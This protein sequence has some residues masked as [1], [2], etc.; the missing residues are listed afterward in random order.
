[1]RKQTYHPGKLLPIIA[2]AA[3]MIKKDPTLLDDIDAESKNDQL[4][5]LRYLLKE[6]IPTLKDPGHCANCGESMAQYVRRVDIFAALLTFQMSKIVLQRVKDGIPFTAANKIRVNA[7]HS[8]AHVLKN[9]TSIARTL[10]LVARY[11][12]KGEGSGALWVVTARGWAAL[13]GDPIPAQVVVFRN[14]IIEHTE[15]TITFPAVFAG[16]TSKARELEVRRKKIK[17]DRRGDY[18]DYDPAE[19]VEIAGMHQGSLL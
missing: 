1:M 9:N 10:G 11:K 5:R 8:I 17:V 14:Q 2:I 7:E 18:L 3:R 12:E 4:F 16:H 19:Y 13:R 15:E 6:A